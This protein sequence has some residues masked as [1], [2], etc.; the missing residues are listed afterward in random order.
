MKQVLRRLRSRAAPRCVSPRGG[1]HARRN[2]WVVLLFL[3]LCGGLPFSFNGAS[4]DELAAKV[5]KIIHSFSP[6]LGITVPVI[7][8]IVPK[9]QRLIS[10]EYA[11]G[12]TDLFQMMF[13]EDFL[14]TLN[15][16]ELRAAIAHELGH[17]WIYTHFPY[18]QTETLA[19]RQALKLVTRSDLAAVYE[20]VWERN[21]ETGN[22]A[23][24]MELEQDSGAKGM[25]GG[26]Y[27]LE[28]AAGGKTARVPAPQGPIIFIEY[29]QPK[30]GARSLTGISPLPPDA[31]PDSLQAVV[32]R[33]RQI[34][35]GCS[36]SASRRVADY[37]ITLAINR[38]PDA[39]QCA[40]T[41]HS[42]NG[43]L[44]DDGET[45]MAAAPAKEISAAVMKHWR[46]NPR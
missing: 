45:S 42:K 4:K 38:R 28:Q 36:V 17:I 44:I 30:T 21:N 13:E 2:F 3:P 20:K 12:R 41:I 33:L 34:C 18:L 40:W 26:V 23:E 39:S 5:Q 1:H 9:N 27:G 10:V 16:T 31:S 11:P 46:G 43:T 29:I 24:L 32:E 37:T 35:P 8:A 7:V 25:R 22:L 15:E 6:R 19:N 14:R